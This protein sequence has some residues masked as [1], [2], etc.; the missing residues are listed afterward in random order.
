M[1]DILVELSS[2]QD[3]TMPEFL[4]IGALPLLMHGY[5]RYTALWDIDLLFR[6]VTDMQT[7][8]RKHKSPTIRIVDYDDDLMVS[9]SLTSYHTAWTSNNTWIN[10]DYILRREL[11]EFYAQGVASST[12]FS[13]RINWQ[14]N[15]YDVS[16]CL[17]KPWD[18]I[19]NK[20]VSPRTARD[21]SLRV[22][23]SIDIRH[24][25]AVCNIEK[26]NTHFW[27]YI[28]SRGSWFGP[29]EIFKKKFLKILRAARDLGYE[30]LEI[31]PVAMEMLS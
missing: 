16:L 12:P 28:M 8:T 31:S 21:I 19:T 26:N 17:A 3:K 11:F 25:F 6:S 15:P 22:D 18:I 10:V 5:L 30:D 23:T 27:K 4:V 7:F 2:I 14:D 24:I 9:E 13:Q 29:E 20:I 1:L